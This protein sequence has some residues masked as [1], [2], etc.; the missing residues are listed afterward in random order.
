M[1]TVDCPICGKSVEFSTILPQPRCSNCNVILKECQD[2][3]AV[4]GTFGEAFNQCHVCRT[5]TPNDRRRQSE[6]QLRRNAQTIKI[7]R[8]SN[9]FLMT[10]VGNGQTFIAID[11]DAVFDFVED[12]FICVHRV[13]GL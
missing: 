7:S 13:I 10:N 1:R 4:Y 8:V 9:G 2:C 5:S 6:L 3:H 12:F 11:I